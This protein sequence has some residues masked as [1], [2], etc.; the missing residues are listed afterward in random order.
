MNEKTYRA[1]EV[2]SC[3]DEGE[4][5]AML[6]NPDKDETVLLNP[7][8]RGIW[9]LLADPLTLEEI[10][11][12]LAAAYPEVTPEQALKDA[13]QFVQSLV[14]GFIIPSPDEH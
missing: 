11:R 4:D 12:Q 9:A 10:A 5:G 1:N 14:P 2:V 6:Y 3:V 7:S 8:G 13:E